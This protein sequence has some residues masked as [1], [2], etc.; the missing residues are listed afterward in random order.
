MP[1]SPQLHTRRTDDDD[2]AAVYA[3]PDHKIQSTFTF[4]KN[5]HIDE[6]CVGRGFDIISHV[7]IEL[8]G[9]LPSFIC[10]RP[11]YRLLD[12]PRK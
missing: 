11:I 4:A 7:Y 5:T 9:S 12:W 1:P 8:S 6:A 2:D 3:A 10:A